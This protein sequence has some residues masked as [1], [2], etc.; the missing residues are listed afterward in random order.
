MN[1]YNYLLNIQH[2]KWRRM[3][4]FFVNVEKLTRDMTLETIFV[5][6]SLILSKIICEF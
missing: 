3:A 5:F 2:W 4:L 1:Y 6:K